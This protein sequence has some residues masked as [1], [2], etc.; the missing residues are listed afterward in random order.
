MKKILVISILFNLFFGFLDFSYW[1]GTY[2]ACKSFKDSGHTDFD[3]Q[4]GFYYNCIHK[5]K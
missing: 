2:T 4:L 5:F 3:W 1:H